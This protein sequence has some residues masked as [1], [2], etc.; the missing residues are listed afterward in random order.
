MT[1]ASFHFDAD[2]YGWAAV[3]ST[4]L[5]SILFV[6]WHWPV[7]RKMSYPDYLVRGGLLLM[8]LTTATSTLI[9]ILEGD[10]YFRRLTN[11]VGGM[12]ILMGLGMLLWQF[13]HQRKTAAMQPLV[14]AL[15]TP[16]VKEI[17]M[18]R[19]ITSTSD[20]DAD[21]AAGYAK[22]WAAF[23][24]LVAIIIINAVPDIH[25]WPQVIANIVVALANLIAV[26][27]LPNKVKPLRVEPMPGNP[28]A[29]Q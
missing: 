4:Y 25:G 27:G 3:V 11:A 14:G 10:S 21:G 17:R 9:N 20:L 13:R 28:V 18:N 12:M 2:A 23:I 8:M 6:V 29:N 5:A 19:T 26:Y 24:N 1:Y 22:S 15:S 16:P 7:L